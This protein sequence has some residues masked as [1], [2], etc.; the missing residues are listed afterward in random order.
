MNNVPEKVTGCK[1]HTFDFI[2]LGGV[3]SCFKYFFTKRN[4][5]RELSFRRDSVT[6]NK[7][8]KSILALIFVKM[9]KDKGVAMKTQ[10]NTIYIQYHSCYR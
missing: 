1:D 5:L 3:H 7:M 10:S 8:L 6:Y 4:N 9:E 2:Q